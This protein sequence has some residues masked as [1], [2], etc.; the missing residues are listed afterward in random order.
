MND[1]KIQQNKILLES[2]TVDRPI[3]D[4][5]K[6]DRKIYGLP[7]GYIY[8]IENIKNHK[9]YIGSTHSS[10]AGVPNTNTKAQLNKRASHYLYEYNSIKNSKTSAKKLIRPLIAAMLEDGFENF[11]MYPLAETTMGTHNKLEKHFIELFDTKD[12]GYNIQKG[13]TSLNRTGRRMMANDKQLRSEGILCININQ[14]KL[15]FSDSMKLFGDF[16]NTSKDMIKNSNRKGRPYKGWFVFYID[17]DKRSLILN[18]NILGNGLRPNDRHSD[19]SKQFY[20]E[21]YDTVNLYLRDYTKSNHFSD[22]E[23]LEPLEYKDQ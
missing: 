13:G 21:L 19:K 15:I 7:F 14:K 8:C 17:P 16:M 6:I 5:Y 18:T 9:K 3:T 1:S 22:F 10:W 20:Q 11:I 4:F 23:V 12:N 2:F